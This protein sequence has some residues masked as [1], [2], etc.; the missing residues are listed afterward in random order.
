MSVFTDNPWEH[1]CHI[2]TDDVAVPFSSFREFVNEYK[3]MNPEGC[4]FDD[5]VLQYFG[6]D[7]DRM[8]MGKYASYWFFSCKY[9]VNPDDGTL[10]S[11]YCPWKNPPEGIVVCSGLCEPR[12]LYTVYKF[13]NLSERTC[14]IDEVY[15][16][17]KTLTPLSALS[18]HN[19][20]ILEPVIK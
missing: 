18:R 19:V 9:K 13:R 20:N 4:Y 17:A 11:E 14:Q 7:I 5:D 3:R 2:Q 16:D 12:E 1:M 10:V 8:R 15:F 6:E